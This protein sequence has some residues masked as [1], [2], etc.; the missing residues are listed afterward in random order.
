MQNHLSDEILAGLIDGTLIAAAREPAVRH[1][2]SCESCRRAYREAGRLAG[3][4]RAVPSGHA[5]DPDLVSLGRSVA[6]GGSETVA[7]GLSRPRLRRRRSVGVL[8]VAAALVAGLLGIDHHRA[9]ERRLQ[10]WNQTLAPVQAAVIE[11][12]NRG[13]FVLPGAEGSLDPLTAATRAG[14]VAPTDS[15]RAAMRRL[16]ALHAQGQAAPAAAQWLAAA[17]IAMGRTDAARDLLE[18]ARSLRPEQPELVTLEAILRFIE[19]DLVQAERDLRLVLERE[20]ENDAARVNLALVLRAGGHREEAAR[21][22]RRVVEDRPGSAL[23]VR[24]RS[25]LESM[26]PP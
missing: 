5:A 13:P 10:D 7:A 19:G 8:V 2:Q 6:V 16:Y 11:A 25:I 21:L 12:S 26:T 24:A 15:L 22:F 4:W 9:A 3:V 14:Y 20:P 18:Q 1:L 17:E 23:A